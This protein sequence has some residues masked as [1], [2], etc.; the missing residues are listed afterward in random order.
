MPD[1]LKAI[2]K[3]MPSKD[4][5]GENVRITIRSKVTLFFMVTDQPMEGK[6]ASSELGDLP[7]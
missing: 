5:N 6:S 1:E 7:L 3:Q 2:K 4:C